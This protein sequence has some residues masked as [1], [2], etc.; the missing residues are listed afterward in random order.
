LLLGATA[1]L[2][3]DPTGVG[4]DPTAGTLVFVD[5][6]TQ[7]HVTSGP[8]T[9]LLNWGTTDACPAP[10]NASAVPVTVDL[11]TKTQDSTA[12]L[13]ASG[14]GP[15]SGSA[16][17]DTVQNLWTNFTNNS[18][19]TFEV[20]IVCSSGSGGTEQSPFVYYQYAYIT[21]NSAA[22][23]FTISSTGPALTATSTT[24]T[25]T[26]TTNTTLGT[27]TANVGDSV[28]FT[29][30]VTDADST[31]AAGTV[32]FQSNG[33]NIGTEP[34]TLSGGQASAST[35]FSSAGPFNITATFAPSNATTYA[36]SNASLTETVQVAGSITASVPENLTVPQNGTFTISVDTAA[37]PITAPTGSFTATGNFGTQNPAAP[38]SATSTAGV[39]VNDSRNT[40]PGWSVTGQT[41]AFTGPGSPAASISGNQLGWTPNTGETFAATGIG[42]ATLGS[43]VTPAAPGL[44]STA[45]TLISAPIG[46]GFGVFDASAML[47]LLIPNTAPPGAYTGTLT[48]TAITHG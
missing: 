6:T 25:S 48:I 4:T 38:N 7:A 41:S 45:A 24:L 39:E 30:H 1:A 21:Y 15:Y 37:I 35:T 18:S 44:G 43:A 13:S 27:N 16:M 5:H 32:T 10:D 19:P 3:S 20:A 22:N 33:T 40:F 17:D 14:A 26:D 46:G 8:G 36:S 34:V 47:T 9:E 42:H 11:N 23:T 31:T 29:A 28:T 2:A 12:G